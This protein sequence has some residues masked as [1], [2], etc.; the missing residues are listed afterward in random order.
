MTICDVLGGTITRSI[1]HKKGWGYEKVLVNNDK[2]CGK[3]LNF[4]A[5]FSCSL[6]YHKDKEETFYLHKGKI[7]IFYHDNVEH[8]EAHLNK[9]K[10]YDILEKITLCQGQTFHVPIGRVHQMRAVEDS[11]LFEFSTH[12]EA[13]DSIRIIKGD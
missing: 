2:Y 5:G 8:I 10:I 3:I 1:V 11:E 7:D 13:D 12:D 6:H 4:V 9:N